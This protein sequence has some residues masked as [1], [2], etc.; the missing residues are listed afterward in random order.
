MGNMPDINKRQVGLRLPLELVH[1]IDRLADVDHLARTDE[2]IKL[3]E[4]GTRDVVL[5]SDDY[6]AIAEEVKENERKRHNG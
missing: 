2:I 6:L 1:K 3:L 4:F 5:T